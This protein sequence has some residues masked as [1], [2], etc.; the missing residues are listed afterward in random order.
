LEPLND[1][2][3]RV[4]FV[5]LQDVIVELLKATLVN[6]DPVKLTV[7]NVLDVKSMPVKLPF[8][9]LDPEDIKYPPP[10]TIADG[11]PVGAGLA[12]IPPLTTPKN[13][14]AVVPENDAP[15]NVEFV[16]VAP[17]KSTELKFT[18]DK[19]ILARFTLLRLAPL[20]FTPAPIMYPFR[21]WYPVGR[22]SPSIVV[23][24]PDVTPVIV[25]PVKLV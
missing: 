12:V 2:L 6:V 21:I 24:P 3:F 1:A 25:A 22:V 8:V 14:A 7:V 16:S 4:V 10:N 15:D 19:F 17:D 18:F 9:A 5:K 13:D 23:I 11:S 20:T